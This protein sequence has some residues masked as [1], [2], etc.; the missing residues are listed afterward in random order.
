MRVLFL[1]NGWIG[2]R[3]ATCL[4]AQ[5]DE[6]V[7]AVLHP[8]ARRSHGD[9]LLEALALP[10]ERIVDG[11]RLREPDVLATLA[12]FGAEIG[13]SA[14]FGHILRR[15]LLDLLP[16]GCVNLHPS[17]LPY[18]RGAHPNVWSIVEGTP[19]G[20][21][22]H[23]V[24]EGVDTGDII[25]QR[26]VPVD[27]ADTGETLYRKL[28]RACVTV[29]DE[30]WPLVRAGCAPRRP[31]PRDAGTTH[32]VADLARLDEIDLDR[33]YTARELIDLLRA[34]T[35]PPHRGVC[36]TDGGRRL[37]LRL[38]LHDADDDAR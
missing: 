30:A 35:F 20:A 3:V 33:R 4:S 13:V 19:A 27:P 37:H 38:E 22:L 24:D 12:G 31:Q 16:A 25:A 32:R 29:F 26:A 2:T 15:D 36:I 17:Y 10:P 9:A 6:I 14:M 34:R 7:G 8:T 5:G 1:G 23:W 18:N 21:T 11:A 28:E